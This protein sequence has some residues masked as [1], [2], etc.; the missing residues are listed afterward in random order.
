VWREEVTPRRRVRAGVLNPPLD[1]VHAI[2]REVAWWTLAV[3]SLIEEAVKLAQ[4]KP[5]LM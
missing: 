5:A 3:V 2:R 1:Q 4:R